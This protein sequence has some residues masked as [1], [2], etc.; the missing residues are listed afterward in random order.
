MPDDR[1][2]IR[3]E[4]DPAYE[5]GRLFRG[6]TEAGN[7]VRGARGPERVAS[8]RVLRRQS[9]LANHGQVSA[10][11]AAVSAPMLLQGAPAAG[12]RQAF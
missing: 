11:V 12:W 2:P 3:A 7:P 5:I 9:T 6:L 8:L 10:K 1:S 4:L